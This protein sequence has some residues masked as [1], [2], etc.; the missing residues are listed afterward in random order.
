[1][2]VGSAVNG[3]GARAR[4]RREAAARFR[5]AARTELTYEVHLADEQDEDSDG[6]TAARQGPRS[7]GGALDETLKR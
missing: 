3:S 5:P 4:E 7:I 1:M 2:T 6:T